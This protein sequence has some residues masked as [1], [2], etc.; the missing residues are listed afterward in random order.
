MRKVYQL[1]A[2]CFTTQI[3][4]E[5]T[6]TINVAYWSTRRERQRPTYDRSILGL[7]QSNYLNSE[8]GQVARL[9]Q[10]ATFGSFQGLRNHRRTSARGR[11]QNRGCSLTTVGTALFQHSSELAALGVI[12]MHRV[13]TF[14]TSFDAADHTWAWIFCINQAPSHFLSCQRSI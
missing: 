11:V 1:R 10:L 14:L 8:P 3:K 4:A 9:A 7:A 2:E 6:P 5:S 13:T 12:N